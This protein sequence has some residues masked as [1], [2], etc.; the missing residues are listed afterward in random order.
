M[1]ETLDL[2]IR[3]ELRKRKMTFGQL[4]EIIGISRPYLSDI[5][6]GKR[7]GEKAKEHIETIKA[8]LKI[9]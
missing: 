4:A 3:I 5:I 6:N 9:S 8:I 1:S 2:K 7:D